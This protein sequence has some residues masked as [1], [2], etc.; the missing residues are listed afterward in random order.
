MGNYN[1]LRFD[2]FINVPLGEI[3]AVRAAAVYAEHDG[4]MESGGDD[5]EDTA[6]RLAFQLAP[7]DD[8]KIGV[9]ADFFRQRGIGPDAT[10]VP[11]GVDNR[12]GIESPANGRSPVSNS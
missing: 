11:L 2:G 12:D 1:A 9:V 10:P 6:G 4:Y 3:A 7:N 8:F 5:Q